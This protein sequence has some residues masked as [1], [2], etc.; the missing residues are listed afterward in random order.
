[1]ARYFFQ[2]KTELNHVLAQIYENKKII[3]GDKTYERKGKIKDHSDKTK[4]MPRNGLMAFCTFYND[5][6]KHTEA[7][8]TRIRFRLKPTVIDERLNKKF[9]IV[10]YPNS[11]FIMS[12]SS[13]RLYT[14]EVIPSILPI[15]KIPIRM[16]Y[17]IRCSKTEAVYKE[18]QTYIVEDDNY[19]KLEEADID[20]IKRLKEFY[21]RENMSE[22]VIDYDKFYFSLNNGD[23]Q[24]PIL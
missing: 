4:D 15:D 13:N 21:F 2:E 1:M 9:D 23:Y 6:K 22:E 20:G 17:V 19:I 12:L 8:L 11:V 10:L 16:G 3:E 18:E 7:E 14:H 5:N 24:K